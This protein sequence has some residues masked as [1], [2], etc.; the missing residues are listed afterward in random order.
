MLEAPGVNLT[1]NKHRQQ[2]QIL[3]FPRE[4]ITMKDK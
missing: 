4:V 3:E 1:N 2:L